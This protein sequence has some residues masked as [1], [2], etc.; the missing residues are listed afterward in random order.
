MIREGWILVCKACCQAP[1][2][3]LH[4]TLT[5]LV[6][7]VALFLGSF[8]ATKGLHSA[9]HL[10]ECLSFLIKSEIVLICF[11]GSD[12]VIYPYITFTVM[13]KTWLMCPL[14]PHNQIRLHPT[15]TNDLRKGWLCELYERK[16]PE[17]LNKW[18]DIL[19][20]WVEGLD[21]IEMSILSS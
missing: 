13:D 8:Q 20:S 10:R 3:L 16:K 6:L 12:P 4:S 21:L 7:G 5:C 15:H 2:S 19:C 1:D 11:I 17:N 9:Y 18:K 14:F